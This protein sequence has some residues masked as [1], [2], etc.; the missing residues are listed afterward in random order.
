[1]S[2]GPLLHI[3]PTVGR[4]EPAPGEAFVHLS[5]AAQVLTPANL[6]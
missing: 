1:M 4:V 3:S 5:R 6:L 2:P